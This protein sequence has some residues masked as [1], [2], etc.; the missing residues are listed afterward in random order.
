MKPPKSRSAASTARREGRPGAASRGALALAGAAGL[1]AALA[2]WTQT[3]ARGFGQAPDTVVT[4]GSVAAAALALGTYLDFRPP[5]GPGP[6]PGRAAGWKLIALGAVTALAAAIAPF[7]PRVMCWAGAD[8][9]AGWAAVAAARAALGGLLIFPAGT[10]AG[11]ALR[12]AVRE[13]PEGRA[14]GGLLAAAGPV[15]LGGA[16]AA[17]ALARHASPAALALGAGAALAAVGAAAVTLHRGRHTS[18]LDPAAEHSAD[19][20]GAWTAGALAFGV[21]AFAFLTARALVPAFAEAMQGRPVA[22]VVFAA[23]LMAGGLAAAAAGRRVRASVAASAA[24]AA[25]LVA[26]V[27][28]VPS[29]YFRFDDLPL[30]FAAAVRSTDSYDAVVGLAFRQAASLALPAAVLLGAAAGLLAAGLPANARARPAWIA[31]GARGAALGAILGL[32]V[33]RFALGPLGLGPDILL[34]AG[35]LALGGAAAFAAPGGRRKLRAAAAALVVAG[36]AVVALRLPPPD[37]RALHL[38]ADIVPVGS[39]SPTVPKHWTVYDRD[40]VLDTFTLLK[41]GHARR[42][43]VNGR[44]EAGSVSEIKSH[45]LLVHLPLVLQAAPRRVCLLGA[46]NGRSILAALGH[47]VAGVDVYVRDGAA[48]GALRRFGP[49]VQPALADERLRFVPGDLRDLLARSDPY[50]LIANHVSGVWAAA[51]ARTSTREF[52]ALVRD[53]LTEQGAYTMCVPATALT[54]EGLLVLLR[55]VSDVFPQVEVWAG[56]GGDVV[57]LA[58]KT[59]APHDFRILLEAYRNPAALLALRDA[60]L[61]DPV[62]L[63]SQFLVGDEAVR[64]LSLRSPVATRRL[65]ELAAAEAERRVRTYGVDPVP[66]LAE[67]GGDVM[68]V[69]ANSPGR[70]L[71][72]AVERAREA[73]ALEREGVEMEIRANQNPAAVTNARIAALDDAAKVYER[74]LDLNPHDG[75]LKRALASA[76]SAIG[77]SYSSKLAFTAAYSNLLQAVEIDSTYAQGFGNLGL[78]LADNEDFGY[79]DATTAKALEL[80]PDDDLLYHQRARIWKRRRFYDRA[81]PYYEKAMEI[82]PLNVEAAM[83]YSDARLSM[84][85]HPD[86]EGNLELLRRLKEIEPDNETIDY[87]IKKI[88]E[89]MAVGIDNLRPELEEDEENVPLLLRESEEADSAAVPRRPANR[90]PGMPQPESGE[91]GG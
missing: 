86:L 33:P 49:A 7:L 31:G 81:L 58:K 37:R 82:N 41:R 9:D 69:L 27:V 17:Q 80:A 21:A 4:L 50:D 35:G 45:G 34:A 63:L 3:L 30:R 14:G 38:E 47:P 25:L 29:V 22:R 56:Q 20:A 15:A 51:S 55:T 23:G 24:G 43:L 73:R 76:R 60:W 16:L 1:G 70:E 61:G 40:G 75:A 62:T 64:R 42:L 85:L 12:A 59:A 54:K 79:A 71:A 39:L 52:L 57:V 46:G 74:G 87:R 28:A 83:G 68:L 5:S 88:Q 84:D 18:S 53:R 2:A 11:A 6:R 48:L 8:A 19:S 36:A 72:V 66:G 89:V 32:A 13:L 90:P 77:I 65:P 10:L 78:L 44:F 67:L 91:G 26:A